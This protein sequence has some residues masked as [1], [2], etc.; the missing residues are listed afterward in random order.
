MERTTVFKNNKT[1]AIRLTKKV[2]LP[3]SVKKVDIIA[4]GRARLIVPADEAWD[5][6]FDGKGVTDDFMNEREQP[7]EQE[8]ET[9]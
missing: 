3:D 6:W 1:Q 5:S 8:R 4:L 9:L 7:Q 2:A